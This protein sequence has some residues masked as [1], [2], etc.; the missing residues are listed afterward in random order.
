M[1]IAGVHSYWENGNLVFYAGNKNN[2]VL[3]LPNAVTGA[4]FN[5]FRSLVNVSPDWGYGMFEDFAPSM[6]TSTTTYPGYTVTV[7]TG[8]TLVMADEVGGVLQLTPGGT[9]N[10][11]IQMQSDG[12]IFLP[13]ANKD[14]WFECR[15][16][17]NDITQVDWMLGLTTTDT[18]IIASIPD[19][20]I[21]FVTHD[22]DDN[23]DFQVRAGGTGA[24]VDTTVDLVATEYMTLGFYINGVT[25]V[26]PYINGTAYTAITTNIPA[27]EMALSFACLTGEAAVNTLDIDWYKIVQKR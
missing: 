23:V 5:L 16:K 7:A 4:N 17:G 27:T 10:Y 26:T 12:E 2:K 11:G 8:G 19:D 1:S 21:G 14:I 3:T 15:V 9:E 25:S 18:A 20:L 22:G 13:A 24:A 6:I